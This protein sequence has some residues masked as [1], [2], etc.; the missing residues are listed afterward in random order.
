LERQRAIFGVERT[1]VS[2]HDSEGK[3]SAGRF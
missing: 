2:M 3:I 1:V